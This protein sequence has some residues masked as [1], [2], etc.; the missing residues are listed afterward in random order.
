MHL[1]VSGS[2]TLRLVYF[3]FPGVSA[4]VVMLHLFRCIRAACLTSLLRAEV[5]AA[6]GN[7]TRVS[8]LALSRSPAELRPQSWPTGAE[9]PE[10]NEPAMVATSSRWLR[11]GVVSTECV[12]PRGCRRSAVLG[13]WRSLVSEEL[14]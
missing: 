11:E 3:G 9:A 14:L 4:R 13:P 10:S 1:L 5:K 6:C 8:R 2:T 7:R 12:E